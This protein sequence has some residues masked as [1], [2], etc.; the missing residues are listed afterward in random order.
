MTTTIS[1]RSKILKRHGIVTTDQQ[2]WQH[3]LID[4]VYTKTHLINDSNDEFDATLDNFKRR[5][6]SK[7][8]AKCL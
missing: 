2:N 1:T 4:L 6:E 7:N 3:P 5:I 8:R